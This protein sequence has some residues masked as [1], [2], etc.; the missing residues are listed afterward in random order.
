MIE[1]DAPLTVERATDHV[2][3][4]TYDR[5]EAMNAYNESLLRGAV[6]A[7]E[8]LDDREEVRAIVLTGTGDAFC[9]GVDLDDMPLTPEM[10]FA[11]Y[12][13]GLDLFQD[14][15]RTLR[16][17]GTPVIAAVN[18]YALGAGC[19]TALACDFRLTSEE[20]VIGETFIDVGFVPG[21]GGAY[22]LPRLVGEA[23]AKE[24]IFTGRKLTGEEI[25]EWD[26]AREQVSADDLL[27][28]AI[29]FAEQL[30]DRPPVALAESK[31]LVNES[32]DVDLER[33]L[34]DATRA[35][36]ICSQT[37]DHAE[38]VEAFAE[39]R[40]PEFEGR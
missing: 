9:A 20:G 8:R 33:G 24:L 5:P 2:A 12:E 25:V 17:I 1:I 26:L 23:R 30:A 18:G 28:T 39:D 4:V 31:Q 36:R 13:A 34:A 38:A 27:D 10:D 19:D 16:G 29:A 15:V 21:D 22:L 37:R 11:E 14:V 7:F 40:E 35:Q 6:E 32:F 3:T